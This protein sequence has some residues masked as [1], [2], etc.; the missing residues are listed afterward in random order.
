MLKSLIRRKALGVVAAVPVALAAAA[1]PAAAFGATEG[2][3][4][5]P[6]ALT[7]YRLHAGHGPPHRASEGKVG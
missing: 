3:L 7:S 6:D 4:A 5:E 2:E 1:I